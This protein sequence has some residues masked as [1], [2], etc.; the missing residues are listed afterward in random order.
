MS[1]EQIVQRVTSD[2]FQRVT[3]ATSKERI[4]QRITSEFQRVTSN[5]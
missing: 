2:F 5:E 1:N 4:L 3:S